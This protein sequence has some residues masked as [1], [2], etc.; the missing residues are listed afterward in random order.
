[1][2]RGRL[3]GCDGRTAPRRA[4]DRRARRQ[5]CQISARAR[6]STSSFVVFSHRTSS[7][8]ILNRRSRSSS[9]AMSPSACRALGS[10]APASTAA[11]GLSP[12][13]TSPLPVA[14]GRQ[15]PP[16]PPQVQRRRMPVPNRLLARRRGVDRVERQRHLDQLFSHSQRRCLRR[17]RR[18]PTVRRR[19]ARAPRRLPSSPT[20]RSPTCPGTIHGTPPPSWPRHPRPQSASGL[21]LSTRGGLQNF[22]RFL[23]RYLQVPRW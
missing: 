5:L 1:M 4:G 11:P 12:A 15:R 21:S 18:S 14:G 19:R 16:R 10:V 3:A 6:F 20:I 13:A 9:A 8:R 22:H 23:G 17:E 2:G 7:S